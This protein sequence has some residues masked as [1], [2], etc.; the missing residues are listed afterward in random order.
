VNMK[1]TISA[2][3]SLPSKARGNRIPS[4]NTTRKHLALAEKLEVLM[5]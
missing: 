4:L 3:E 5:P 2:D 1:A